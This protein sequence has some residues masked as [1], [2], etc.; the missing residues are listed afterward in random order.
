MSKENAHAAWRSAEQIKRLSDRL[1]GVGPIGIGLDGMLAWIP[2]ANLVYGLS[3][4]GL[5]LMHAVR[6]EA[7]PMTMAKMAT[8]LAIDN[9]T[10]AVPVI[11]WAADT[12]F[13]G[14]LMAAKALQ[15]DIEQRHG[16]PADVE[17]SLRKKRWWSGRQP[18]RVDS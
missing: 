6:A 4:G 2:G 15:K 12:L 1:I 9:L 18:V 17:V 16:L 3:A 14:H 7:R 10:D 5:L 8:Y 13:P 11:G